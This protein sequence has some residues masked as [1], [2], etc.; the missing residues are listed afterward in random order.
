MY[1]EKELREIYGN[2]YCGNN[3]QN[4]KDFKEIK[5]VAALLK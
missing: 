5:S 2:V 1:N 3:K 4:R